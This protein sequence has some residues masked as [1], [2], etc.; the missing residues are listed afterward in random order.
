ME[1]KMNWEGLKVSLVTAA[2]KKATLDEALVHVFDV[3]DPDNVGDLGGE[4]AV[5][6]SGT[7]SLEHTWQT[8]EPWQRRGE[9]VGFF[10]YLY[11]ALA[12]EI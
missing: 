3:I 8:L 7:D 11:D 9:F 10:R 5:Y 6:F 2:I 4:A 12:D 1:N